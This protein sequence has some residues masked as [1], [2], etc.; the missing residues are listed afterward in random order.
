MQIEEVIRRD[1]DKLYD[2]FNRGVR[3]LNNT[4]IL[5]GKRWYSL[6]LESNEHDNQKDS[7]AKRNIVLR[8]IDR[9]VELIK[10]IGSKI[11]E[12]YRKCKAAIARFFSKKE[13]SPK[14][15]SERFSR[16]TKDI[17]DE[18]IFRVIANLSDRSKKA[19][20]SISD[21]TCYRALDSLYSDYSKISSNSRS[22]TEFSN[23]KDFFEEYLVNYT[24][25]NDSSKLAEVSADKLISDLLK[26]NS[27]KVIAGVSDMFTDIDKQ[28]SKIDS[29]LQS[30]L[31]DISNS[32]D[33]NE[34]RV[35]VKLI[36][37]VITSNSKLVLAIN[38]IAY[39]VSEVMIA[40]VRSKFKHIVFIP[41]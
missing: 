19:L 38:A 39:A 25:F 7:G 17:T 33:S 11:A 24:K 14:D 32:D 27:G 31:K 37:D 4:H 15:I 16:L 22:I 8:M 29:S 36:S 40:L 30:L 21:N 10:G 28:Q 5:T 9:L 20:S 41:H 34:Q 23:K 18:Q 1:C 2:T 13:P 6:G 35:L 12:W 3:E 26:D